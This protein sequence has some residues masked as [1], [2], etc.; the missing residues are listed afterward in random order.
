MLSFAMSIGFATFPVV[1]TRLEP[2]SATFMGCTPFF[3]S[4]QVIYL[5]YVAVTV[6]GD[7]LSSTAANVSYMRL[8][9]NTWT[10]GV[11]TGATITRIVGIF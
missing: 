10:H 11:T 9:P 1:C 4:E 7:E 3:S 6:Q 8:D 2:G 5:L